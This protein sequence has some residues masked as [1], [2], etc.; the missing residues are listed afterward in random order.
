MLYEAPLLQI[1]SNLPRS[2]W[3]DKTSTMH[4]TSTV[5][6]ISIPLHT[7][8]RL[9]QHESKLATLT[10]IN[11][12]LQKENEQ[13]REGLEAAQHPG[14]LAEEE[15]LDLKEE[16]ARRLGS[17]DKTVAELRV[18]LCPLFGICCH[19]WARQ[20]G[21]RNGNVRWGHLW[22][23]SRHWTA[24][25][26]LAKLWLQSGQG[27]LGGKGQR[28]ALCKTSRQAGNRA[29]GKRLCEACSIQQTAL[30]HTQMREDHK[31]RCCWAGQ[32]AV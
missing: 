15:L 22:N 6:F 29:T 21:D 7:P 11:G 13:L 23:H 27:Q 16:F 30:W 32:R 17:A 24:D 14:S 12:A 1:A 8:Y 5:E 4:K 2:I 20:D 25:R 9:R 28:N 31:S 19:P 10:I 3:T 18:R 26:A